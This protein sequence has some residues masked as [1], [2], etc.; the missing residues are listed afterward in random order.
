MI[1]KEQIKEWNK[2][3][4]KGTIPDNE[5]PIFAFSMTSTKLLVKFVNGE[6][7]AIELMRHELKNRG[8][9]D[10]GSYIGFNVKEEE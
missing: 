8:L 5:N 7:E 2:A 4:M 6:L 3:A 9:G 10:D 1:S